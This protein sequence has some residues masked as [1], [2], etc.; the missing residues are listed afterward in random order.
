MSTFSIHLLNSNVH[1]RE[2]FDCGVVE[3]NR[4]LK[5]Q[6]GQD[7]RRMASGCWVMS[8]ERD[9]ERI[10]GFYT[11]SPESVESQSLPEM[12]SA[13]RKK[14]PNYR[15]LGAILLGRLAVDRHYQGQ[16]IGERLLFDAFHR[17]HRAEIPS[18]LMVTDPKDAKAEAFYV[19]YGFE[20]LNSERLFL[21]M[22]R[23]SKLLE[24]AD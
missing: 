7:M 14:I 19:K 13:I 8:D 12:E 22:F 21:P 1:R 2:T 17:A 20:R 23:I 24:S 16:G 11:L 3:L 9:P 10:L 5:E 15:R 6:A 4:Y 18:V